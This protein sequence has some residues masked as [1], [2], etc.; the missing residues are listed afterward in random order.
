MERKAAGGNDAMNMRMSFE[1]LAPRVQHAE[2]TN[3]RTEVSRITRNFLKRFGTGAK[4]KIV[5]NLLVLQNQWCQTVGQCEDDVQVAGREKFSSTRSNPAFSS[6][7]LTLRA[8]A[9]SARIKSDG[10]MPAA[11]ALIEMTAECGGTT[12]L[13]GQQH[14]D[15]LPTEPVA[16]SFYESIPGSADD[17]GHLQRWPAHLFL[18]WRLGV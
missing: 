15:M 11:G 18:V 3:F 17:I 2:E 16:V 8:V 1:L 9:I 10:P 4:Q 13:N 14:F 12:P 7:D 6:S 5:K